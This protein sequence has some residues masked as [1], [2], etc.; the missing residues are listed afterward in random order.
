M[1]N[2]ITPIGER[3][4]DFV[5]FILAPQSMLEDMIESQFFNGKSMGSWLRDHEIEYF[6]YMEQKGFFAIAHYKVSKKDFNFI[7]LA[8]P[9]SAINVCYTA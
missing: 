4:Q 3:E 6:I 1:Q 7:R 8:L 9:E 5:D 2:S